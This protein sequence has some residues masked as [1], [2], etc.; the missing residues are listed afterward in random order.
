MNS[1]GNKRIHTK[2]SVVQIHQRRTYE[3]FSRSLLHNSIYYA[4]YLSQNIIRCKQH[5]SI[6]N[7]FYIPLLYSPVPTLHLP[8]RQQHFLHPLAPFIKSSGCGPWFDSTGNEL[9]KILYPTVTPFFLVSHPATFVTTPTHSTTNVHYPAC[10][11]NNTVTKK[12]QHKSRH[13]R[14]WTK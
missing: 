6:L 7:I 11:C 10:E 3:L 14:R 12:L 9:N 5:N 2:S 8:S 4:F 13:Y 1:K